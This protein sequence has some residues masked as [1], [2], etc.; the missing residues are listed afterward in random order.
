LAGLESVRTVGYPLRY[1]GEWHIDREGLRAAAGP[2][3][4][5]IVAVSPNNPTGSFLKEA[6]LAFLDG[7]C[8]ERSLSLLCDEVF[9]DFPLE[10]PA[11]RISGV[12]GRTRAL[13]FTL[14][15]ASKIAAL[16]QLKIGW[17]VASGPPALVEP[18]MQRLELIADTYL[19]PSTPSQLALP[20]VLSQRALAQG[21]LLERLEQNLGAL[22]ALH[23]VRSSWQPL[24]V[25]G[26]W[27]AVLQ[28]PNTLSEQD[29]ALR[30]LDE[31]V[32][33]HPGYFYDFPKPAFLAVSLIV[34]PEV[35]DEGL[36]RVARCLDAA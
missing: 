15:G 10:A 2:R 29:W 20:Q 21:P 14:N 6:E 7:F 27:S 24:R 1:D 22:R 5:A 33:V 31:G 17:L 19:S 18:A 23:G 25:E 8:A 13:S 11:D 16:P 32:L 4:R 36:A 3:T 9:A 35:L 28:V 26:G 34:R 30:L 12:L